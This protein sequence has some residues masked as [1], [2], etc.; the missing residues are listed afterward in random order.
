MIEHAPYYGS[1]YDT[2]IAGQR[3]AIVGHSHWRDDNERD[4]EAFTIEVVSK[5]IS[6]EYQTKIAFWKQISGYFGCKDYQDFWNRILFF[7]FLPDCIGPP[8]ER[9]KSGSRVQIGRA[10]QRFFEIVRGQHHPRPNKVFVFSR[11]VW[12]CLAPTLQQKGP[13]NGFDRFWWGTC[14]RDGQTV[15]AFGLRHPQGARGALMRE[16]VRAIIE[17][18]VAGKAIE[19]ERV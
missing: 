9:F 3:I 13:L 1:D 15:S 19:P 6:G 14:N 8:D 10:P 5:V 7:N 12:D 18:P 17:L 2:G 16:A 4:R 11:K